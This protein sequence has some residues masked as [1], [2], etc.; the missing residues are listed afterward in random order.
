MKDLRLLWSDKLE[1]A[2]VVE[3][4]V[5]VQGTGTQSSEEILTNVG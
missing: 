2:L 3:A 5:V 4:L 1:E